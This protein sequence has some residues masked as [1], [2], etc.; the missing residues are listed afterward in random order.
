MS[1][2]II[3]DW[4]GTLLNDVKACVDSMNCM[5]DK[6]SVNKITID[7]Y[8]S[9]FTFP[10]K[11]Y[12]QE[13]GF[14]FNKEPF[15]ELSI[16]YIDLY[17]RNSMGSPLQEGVIELLNFFKSRKYKQV[18][19]SASEQIALENQ[20]KQRN[21]FNYFDSLIGLNNIHA[22]GKV[23]NAKNFIVN[24]PG[25]DQIILIGDTMHDLEVAQEINAKCILVSNG[26]QVIDREK[27]NGNAV[28]VNTL[29]DITKLN[30]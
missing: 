18:I 7:Y 13:L 8:K 16:E 25:Y 5:L 15:E 2:L 27:F 4:N 24:S 29:L 1:K 20:V 30:L 22:K 21:I 14:D 28:I 19:L 26:H 9:I 10:V 23:D 12:Y 6:R 17:K 3:W 11:K